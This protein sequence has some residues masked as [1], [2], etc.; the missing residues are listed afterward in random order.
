MKELCSGEETT[1]SKTL[2]V[3]L[4]KHGAKAFLVTS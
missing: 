4:N 3:K 2:K 1:V